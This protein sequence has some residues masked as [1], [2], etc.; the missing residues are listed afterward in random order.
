MSGEPAK[1]ITLN[2]SDKQTFIVEETIALQSKTLELMIADIETETIVIHLPSI[3][4]NILAKVIEYCNKHAEVATS[5]EDK[6]L[7]DAQF[8]NFVSTDILFSI[9]LAADSLNIEGLLD[10]FENFFNK[11]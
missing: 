1:M 2:S 10:F 9:T 11:R 6:R 3:T 8:V 4:G 7:W 5:D